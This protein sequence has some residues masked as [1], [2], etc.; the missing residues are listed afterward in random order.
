MVRKECRRILLVV[1]AMMLVL[2]GLTGCTKDTPITDRDDTHYTRAEEDDQ[3]ATV[4]ESGED[5]ENQTSAAEHR[6][7]I[8]SEDPAE[9]KAFLQTFLDA[10]RAQDPQA[11]YYLTGAG[12][13]SLS[14]NGFQGLLASGFTY[15]IGEVDMSYAVPYV[16]V[17]I[18]NV[19]FMSILETYLASLSNEATYA[20][21]QILQDLTALIQKEDHPVRT[22]ECLVPVYYLDEDSGM[23]IEMTQ[24]LSNALTGGL[25]EF[26][27]DYLWQNAG[28]GQ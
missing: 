1:L 24:E 5:Q 9:C 25:A 21:E 14:Y 12:E 18:T 26:I 27:S 22:F 6:E 8:H 13:E 20:D 17:T 10:Y 16:T 3:E 19:D 23:K 28:Q 2:S 11:V 7:Y 15:E 4:Y